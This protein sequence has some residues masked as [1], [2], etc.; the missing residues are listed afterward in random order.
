MTDKLVRLED[1]IK[2]IDTQFTG[3]LHTVMMLE[4]DGIIPV[5]P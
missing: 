4:L 1:V 5:N 3:N 2:I